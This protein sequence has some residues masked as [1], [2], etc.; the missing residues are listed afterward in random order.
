VVLI[1]TKTHQVTHQVEAMPEY[2]SA[3]RVSGHRY[4]KQDPSACDSGIVYE[5]LC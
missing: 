1:I 4:P 3:S 2:A 5:C